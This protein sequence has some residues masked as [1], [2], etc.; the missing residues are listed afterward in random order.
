MSQCKDIAWGGKH[1]PTWLGELF[2]LVSVVLLLNSVT[3]L[4]V[5]KPHPNLEAQ[6]IK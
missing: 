4:I 5:D 2:G 6:K 3:K 1:H